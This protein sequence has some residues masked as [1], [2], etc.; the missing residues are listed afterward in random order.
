MVFI[1]KRHPGGTAKAVYGEATHSQVPRDGR[2]PTVHDLP[3]EASRSAKMGEGRSD[4]N[5]YAHGGAAR[6]RNQGGDRGSAPTLGSKCRDPCPEG[7]G[8]RRGEGEGGEGDPNPEGAGVRGAGPEGADGPEGGG[9]WPRG[10]RRPRGGAGPE[11]ADGPEGG[12]PRGGR[13]RGGRPRG[14]RPRGGSVRSPPAGKRKRERQRRPAGGS[15]RSPPADVSKTRRCRGRRQQ[16]RDEEGTRQ[17]AK[18]EGGWEGREQAP[19]RHPRR[20]GAGGRGGVPE[21]RGAGAKGWAGPVR[22]GDRRGAGWAR[23]VKR[24]QGRRG[25]R[26]EACRRGDLSDGK[27]VTQSGATQP[28][29]WSTARRAQV[30]VLRGACGAGGGSWPAAPMGGNLT[31]ADTICIR[32][33]HRRRYFPE[34]TLPHNLHFFIFFEVTNGQHFTKICSAAMQSPNASAARVEGTAPASQSDQKR[35]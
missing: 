6:K 32:K 30:R 22:R 26:R 12:R 21:A 7:G 11:G 31:C 14:G 15:A 8:G 13:P 19:R 20:E 27:D 17:K 34:R 16:E 29:S 1:T 3:C 10:G 33:F 5:L 35:A 9:G 25:G 18:R 4:R 2:R 28:R 23:S 24:G